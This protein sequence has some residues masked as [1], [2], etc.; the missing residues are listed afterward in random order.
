VSLGAAVLADPVEEPGGM[1]IVH[2]DP[3]GHPFLPLHGAVTG[4][5]SS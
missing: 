4:L 1:F 5:T 2:A 3:A